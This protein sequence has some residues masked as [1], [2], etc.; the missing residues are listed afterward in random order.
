MSQPSGP[1]ARRATHADWPSGAC[2]ST[3]DCS[4]RSRTAPIHADDR[5]G[6]LRVARYSAR[7]PIGE[8]RLRYDAERAQ[9]E[10]VCDRNDGPYA[11]THRF[12]ALEFLA[13]WVDHVL[14]RYETRVRYYGAYAT[15]RRVW[16]R[17]RG[18]VLVETPVAAP[19]DVP[20]PP[21]GK[22]DRNR[23]DSDTLK[24]G[25]AEARGGGASCRLDERSPAVAPGGH[26][27]P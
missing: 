3:S 21:D 24:H 27:R 15:R 4:P 7:A 19:R 1:L 10:L 9:V 16:W 22:R 5:D 14:E 11:G 20:E 2:G 6:L 12:A 23:A 13:R 17:R 25:T 26:S 18:V 8:P